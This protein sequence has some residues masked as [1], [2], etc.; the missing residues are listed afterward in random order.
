[1]CNEKSNVATIE[2]NLNNQATASSVDNLDLKKQNQSLVFSNENLGI[3]S[4]MTS[5]TVDEYD[6]QFLSKSTLSLTNTTP[7]KT[8]FNPLQVI[9]KDKNKYYTTEYV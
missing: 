4:G 2:N 3:I 6:S 5:E 1:M 7:R 9:L 8:P